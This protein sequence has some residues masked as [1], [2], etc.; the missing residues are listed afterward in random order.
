[1]TITQKDNASLP[2]KPHTITTNTKDNITKDKR[3]ESTPSKIAKNFFTSLE[4]QERVI[5]EIAEKYKINPLQVKQ[6]IVKFISYWT[7]PN[8]SGTKQRWELE[9]TFEVSRRLATWFSRINTFN[10]T[11]KSKFTSI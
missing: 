10:Q 2:K 7:E 8:K 1:M 6:E 9:Q 11:N 5:T 3:E 4:E